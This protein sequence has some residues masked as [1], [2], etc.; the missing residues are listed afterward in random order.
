M[1]NGLLL[2]M[3]VT[4]NIYDRLVQ[5]HI[6]LIMHNIRAVFVLCCG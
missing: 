1:I 4:S 3:T 2:Q 6:Q 5:K